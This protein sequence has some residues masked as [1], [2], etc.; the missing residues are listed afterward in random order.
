MPDVEIRPIPASVILHPSSFIQGALFQ[1]PALNRTWDPGVRQR[2]VRW[3]ARPRS[4]SLDS[5][6]RRPGVTTLRL[7][8]GRSRPILRIGSDAHLLREMR[9]FLR[10][11]YVVFL[12]LTG[13]CFVLS[14]TGSGLETAAGLFLCGVALRTLAVYQH[15]GHLRGVPR[16]SPAG[17]FRAA[18]ALYFGAGAL[19]LVAAFTSLALPSALIFAY[20]VVVWMWMCGGV[21]WELTVRTEPRADSRIADSRPS[22]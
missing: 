13:I 14:G 22:N 1:H 6:P 16:L 11:A 8:L 2:G 9:R 4:K 12:M 20:F 3:P 5:A 15:A 17:G 18:Y 21:L 7:N 10:A 19:A